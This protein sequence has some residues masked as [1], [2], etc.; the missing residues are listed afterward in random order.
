MRQQKSES[1]F[2]R[3]SRASH[4]EQGALEMKIL[5]ES[6]YKPGRGGHAPGDLRDAFR[7]ALLAFD[8]WQPGQPEPGVKLRD[9]VVPISDVFGLLWD[10]SDILPSTLW[11]ILCD[12]DA[13]DPETGMKSRTYGA[14]S[15]WLRDQ[16]RLAS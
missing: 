11:G 9:Q 13:E 14:A 10:C 16:M 3:P 5:N 2:V 7:D 4:V 8:E 6:F 15:R 1:D 12:L